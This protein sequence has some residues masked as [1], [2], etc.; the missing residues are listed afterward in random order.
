MIF[1]THD[2]ETITGVYSGDP[3]KLG[4]E[5]ITV[6]DTFQGRKGMPLGMLDSQWKVRPMRELIAD[7]Y[8]EK[9]EG[10]V[11]DE[12]ENDWRV[13]TEAELV[14][15]GRRELGEREKIEGDMV[16][17]KKM[18]EL[19]AE[20]LLTA[21]EKSAWEKGKALQRLNEL[22]T[23]AVR[24]IRAILAGANTQA[25]RDKLASLE[26]EAQQLRRKLTRQLS[27]A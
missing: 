11:W 15:D 13:A 4:R 21:E 22:D 6:P 26:A 10:L 9:P 18:E 20:G 16:V 12:T 14:A 19:D 8:I 27:G 5:T 1:I 17:P 25:D 23:L 24:P 2:G 7:G 3:S